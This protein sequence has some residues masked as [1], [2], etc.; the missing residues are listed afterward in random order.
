MLLVHVLYVHPVERL[1][2]QMYSSALRCYTY[3]GNAYTQEVILSTTVHSCYYPIR[4]GRMCGIK[5]KSTR[6]TF[7]RKA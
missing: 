6:D 1:L 2:L 4:V 7:P 5:L 3:W